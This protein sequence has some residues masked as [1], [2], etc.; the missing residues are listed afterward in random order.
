L[1]KP[2]TDND[3]KRATRRSGAAGF[4]LIEL[5]IVLAIMGILL[6]IAQPSLRQSVVRA[7]EAVLREDLFQMREAI[8]QFYADTGKYPNSLTDLMNAQERSHSYLR[9]LPKDPITG[10]PDWITVA[11]EGSDEG[12]VFDVHSASPLVAIDGTAYNAW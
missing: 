7:R 1:T 9:V 5:M 12:G 2:V 8:D 10:A 4:T 11:P 6:S 3:G